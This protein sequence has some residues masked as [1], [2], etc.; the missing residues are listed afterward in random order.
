MNAILTFTLSLLLAL[1]PAAAPISGQQAAALL[2][3]DA[4]YCYTDAETGLILYQQSGLFG[5]M[6]QNGDI[7]LGPTY[8]QPF[9]FSNGLAAVRLPE[10]FGYLLPDGTELLR[11]LDDAYPFCGEYA[12][13]ILD[14][15]Y[16][17]LD[18]SG[19]WV[20]K[21]IYD[22][23]DAPEDGQCAAVLAGKDVTVAVPG[24]TDAAE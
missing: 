7:V 18:Q 1:S 8:V 15:H 2:P 3:E 12:I 24:W 11:G 13:A 20:L 10:S 19:A 16:G 5:L 4:L 17:L 6:A 21:P 9:F 14:E 23:L 22:G